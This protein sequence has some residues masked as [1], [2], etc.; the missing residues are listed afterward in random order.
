MP[1]FKNRKL[2][3][4]SALRI[5][6]S[7]ARH[8]NFTRAAE[9]LNLTQSSI[10]HQIRKLEEWMEL[11]LFERVGRSVK[12]A[13]TGREL[14]NTMSTILDTLTS[15]I[16]RIS[17]KD[18]PERLYITTLDSISVQWLIPR[19]NDFQAKYPQ[20]DIQLSTSARFY[21]MEREADFAIRYCNDAPPNLVQET[22]FDELVFPV[23]APSLSKKMEGETLTE[24]LADVPLLYHQPEHHS[25]VFDWSF[26]LE[27]SG[28]SLPK[29]IR[30]ATYNY[31]H[32]LTQAAA[33]GAGVCIGSTVLT[34]DSILNG[35]L[36]PLSGPQIDTGYS[37]KLLS[38]RMKE[39]TLNHRRFRKWMRAQA[40]SFNA[41]I[42]EFLNT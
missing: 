24:Q 9:E 18:Q 37:Y 20:I 27:E 28:I 14:A 22:L 7:A 35:L 5:F 16:E 15:D 4:L 39:S 30:G 12:L 38:S 6:E 13:D 23:C 32:M 25:L 29:S 11:E 17:K 8:D 34:G 3:S 42:N 19:L 41:N 26:W 40:E 36:C 2:P 21:D 10:S 1:K 31:S 33:S